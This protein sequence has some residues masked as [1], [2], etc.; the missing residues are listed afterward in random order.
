[1]NCIK[2]ALIFLFICLVIILTL[3]TNSK[4]DI[5]QF[6]F[7]PIEIITSEQMVIDT[8]HAI[9]DD[10]KTKCLGEAEMKIL[11]L[12]TGIAVEM[13]CIAEEV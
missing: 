8:L 9:Q 2:E 6:Y 5:H 7:I 3:V 4:A 13:L 1:M 11:P 10:F 12:H